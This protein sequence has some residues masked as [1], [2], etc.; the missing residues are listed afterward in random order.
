M[1]N[2][3][4]TF[5]MTFNKFMDL[6]Q[7]EFK[8]TYL[9]TKPKNTDKNYV[10]LP[11]VETP[12]TLDWRSKNAVSKVKNQEQCGSCWSFSTTGA[13]ESLHYLHTKK[14]TLFSE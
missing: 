9:N 11:E 8:K 1:K 12:T 7:E 5:D 6:T 2:K 10:Y 4:R 14:M 3:D 13:L